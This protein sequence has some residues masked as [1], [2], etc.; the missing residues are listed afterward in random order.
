VIEA[1]ARVVAKEGE[2]AWVE[3]SRRSACDRCS[4]AGGC[5]TSVLAR[6]FDRRTTRL[7]AID[8]VGTRVG[9]WV[10]IGLDEGAMLRGALLVY[11]VPLG[12]LILGAVL[13]NATLGAGDLT[14]LLGAGGG[15]LGALAWSRDRSARFRYDERFHPIVLHRLRPAT[16]SDPRPAPRS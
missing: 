12:G 9:D 4:L 16:T 2:L 15:F 8:P 14:G 5:G 3:A 13:A 1:E 7:R 10:S 11:A 6:L